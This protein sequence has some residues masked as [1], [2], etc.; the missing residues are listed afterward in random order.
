MTEALARPAA[1]PLLLLAS[2]SAA[3]AYPLLWD[4][5]L[6]DAALILLK[7]AGVGLLA[8]LAATQAR[9]T[10]GWLLAAVMAFGALGDMLLEISFE[11]GA[12]A[13][14]LGHV[15][16]IA[17]YRR[18][19]RASPSTSQWLLAAA[20]P[21][22]GA[23][24]PLLLLGSGS[25]QLIGFTIYSL[26]LTSMA[27]AAWLSRF[28]LYR[29]GLGALLFVVSDTLIAA[30]VGP[31]GNAAWASYAIWLLYYLGQLLIFLG[32]SATLRSDRR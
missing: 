16:A 17:L 13:F 25:P 30:R 2:L 20:L 19:R 1:V 10:D 22:F 28:P 14:A 15:V 24:M 32:V 29:T 12:A 23:A 7:G 4:A 9:S 18:N 3:L 31:L 11:V 27:A 26:L 5:G 8:L 21:L 6:G